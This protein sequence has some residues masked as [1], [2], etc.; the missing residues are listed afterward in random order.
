MPS[1]IFNEPLIKSN[2]HTL[3]FKNLIFNNYFPLGKRLENPYGNASQP[4]SN[5]V[6]KKK[7]VVK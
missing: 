4:L 5:S 6:L 3:N 7:I 1:K 2:E